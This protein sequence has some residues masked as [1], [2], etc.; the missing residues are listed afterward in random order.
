MAGRW[1]LCLS[2]AALLA[3]VV[4]ADR[5]AAF[6]AKAGYI[7]DGGTAAQRQQVRAALEASW[8]DWSQLRAPVIVHIRRIGVSHATPGHVWLDTDLLNSGKFA[9]ATVLDEFAHQVDYQLLNP[10]HRSLLARELDASAWC[11]ET[12]GLSHSSYGCERFASVFAWAYGP[13]IES[14][15]RPRSRHEE[16]A[17]MPAPAFRRLLTRLLSTS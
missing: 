17:A 10:D 2:L 7:F 9:W 6:N 1:L 15:Y 14:S 5:A 16:S 13:S 4:A 3:S 12:P 11:Y 8:F